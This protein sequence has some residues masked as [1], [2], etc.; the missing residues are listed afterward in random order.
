MMNNIYPLYKS[1][2]KLLVIQAHTD[3]LAHLDSKQSTQR[4]LRHLLVELGVFSTGR[5]HGTTVRDSLSL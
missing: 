3:I 1:D 4:R 2:R 5:R